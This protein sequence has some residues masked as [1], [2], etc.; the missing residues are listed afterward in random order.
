M[1]PAQATDHKLATTSKVRP[2]QRTIGLHLINAVAR[3]E[4]AKCPALDL[5]VD[6]KT[7]LPFDYPGSPHAQGFVNQVAFSGPLYHQDT[8]EP[9]FEGTSTLVLDDHR[10]IGVVVNGQMDTGSVRPDGALV[11]WSLDYCHIH[12]VRL[13]NNKGGREGIVLDLADHSRLEMNTSRRLNQKEWFP[14]DLEEFFELLRSTVMGTEQEPATQ[15]P[16]PVPPEPKAHHQGPASPSGFETHLSSYL[17]TM[18]RF[19]DFQGRSSRRE[20]WT[21]SFV[22]VLVAFLTVAIT[23]SLP[24]LSSIALLGYFLITFVPS[25]SVLVRRLHDVGRSG[26][27]AWLSLIPFIGPVVLLVLQLQPG[28]PRSNRY[29]PPTGTPADSQGAV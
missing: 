17:S 19:A 16:A 4:I 23:F 29:G 1:S 6:G 3:D 22:N 10:I 14:V 24:E 18:R 28:D 20:F 2:G 25:V 8:Q 7:F 21:F 13:V 11:A 9:I 15:R 27:T 26:A 12:D 5:A